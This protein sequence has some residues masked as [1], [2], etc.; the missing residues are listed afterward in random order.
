[1]T[2]FLPRLAII[3][4]NYGSHKLLEKNL[5]AVAGHTASARIVVVDSYS[6][7]QERR[8]VEELTVKFGW[9]LLTPDTNVGFGR[10]A[11]IGVQHACGLG[12]ECFLLLNPD[13]VLDKESLN[14]L[15]EAVADRPH[16]LF[17]PTVLRP[18]GSVWFNGADLY[19]D[20]GLTASAGRRGMNGMARTEPWLSGACLMASRDLWELVGGFDEEYFLY[21]EDVDISHRVRQAGGALAV[22]THAHA[23]HDEG[24]TQ[25]RGRQ[26]LGSVAKSSTYYYF[27]I[28]NRLLY[29]AR[30]LDNSDLARWTVTTLWA[31]CEILLRGGRRQFIRP[32]APV[33]AALLGIRDGLRVAAKERRRRA[34]LERGRGPLADNQR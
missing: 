20:T 12:A 15:W 31:S 21:W 27:N 19:L 5:V 7:A 11:N 9:E 10:G 28:R 1:V 30:H 17:S 26:E 25:R 23:V 13:A 22:L 34:R 29:G 2:D 14:L 24:G 3:V 16:T 4:V 33:S 32:R 8:D 6:S 18:D